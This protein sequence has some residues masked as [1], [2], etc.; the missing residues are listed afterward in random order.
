MGESKAMTL[1]AYTSL[2]YPDAE[3]R[4]NAEIRHSAQYAGFMA[5]IDGNT[6]YKTRWSCDETF[7][8][9]WSRQ[10]EAWGS[11]PKG[12]A[13]QFYNEWCQRGR[14]ADIATLPDVGTGSY[15]SVVKR[16]NEAL[17]SELVGKG[18]T[19]S[20]AEKLT[21]LRMQVVSLIRRFEREKEY[22]PSLH[23]SY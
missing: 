20:E 16:E 10:R 14:Q 7:S 13:Q 19:L 6:N 9:F 1:S 4:K 5:A 18:W 17:K 21:D 8:Y 11:V 22:W 15:Y 3:A 23:A 2:G 12:E